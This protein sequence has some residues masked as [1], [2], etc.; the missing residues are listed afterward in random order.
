MMRQGFGLKVGRTPVRIPFAT[1][2]GPFVTS[3]VEGK[4]IRKRIAMTEARFG[5]LLSP[6]GSLKDEV[7][8]V[9]QRVIFEL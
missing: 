8:V 2:E 3:V 6:R 1:V 7:E 9:V 5:M 4:R